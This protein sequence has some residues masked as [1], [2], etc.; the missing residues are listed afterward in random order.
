MV[1]QARTMMERQLHQMIR[2]VDD[3]LDVSRVSRG[4][5]ELKREAID[6]RTALSNAVET[7]KPAIDQNAQ[8]LVI[9]VDGSAITVDGDL[10]RLSQVFANLLNNAAKYTERG[11]RI[12]VSARV[13]DG[14]AVVRVKDDGIGIPAAMLERVFDIFTQV[15]RSLEKA[16]GGLGIGLSIARRLVEMH[17]GTIAAES[18][19]VGKGSEFVVRLP[20]IARP[21][22]DA[23]PAAL[24]RNET[25]HRRRVLVADDNLD[26]A[27]SLSLVLQ[28]MGNDVRVAND[29]F[30]AIA[31]AESFHPDAIFLDI[32]MPGLNGY[33][34]C[35]K[36]RENGAAAGAVVVALT[37]WGQ[38]EDR[39]RSQEFGFDHH[40]VKPVEPSILETLLRGL[41]PGP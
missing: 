24:S 28:M 25:G 8:A 11:G 21:A 41:P 36:L 18:A 2:L 35:R 17:G 37:G 9:D 5:I 3:L 38:Q 1:E 33:E 30:E 13:V 39:R 19:G 20:G 31:V 34:V 32:G 26:S 16:R 29:G 7:A 27:S 6:L 23:A 22:S 4:K 10:T 14:I 12:E 15:D 40:L